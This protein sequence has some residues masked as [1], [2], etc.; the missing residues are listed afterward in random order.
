MFKFVFLSKA[1]AFVILNASLAFSPCMKMPFRFPAKPP[2]K[3]AAV[4]E[5]VVQ[6]P[7]A[8]KD[9][10]DVEEDLCSSEGINY[11]ENDAVNAAE[12]PDGMD[13]PTEDTESESDTV[14]VKIVDGKIIE[15]GSEEDLCSSEGINYPE[16]DA[17]IPDGMDDPTEDTESESDT[18]EVKIVDGKI[19]E[20]GSEDDLVAV[21]DVDDEEEKLH[22][23]GSPVV[24]DQDGNMIV[25][26]EMS[27]L[28]S[29]VAFDQDGNVIVEE[30][31]SAVGTP[32]VAALG[33]PTVAAV[34]TPT[35]A[36][37]DAIVEDDEEDLC[38]SEGI[39]YPEND[40]D[41]EATDSAEIDDTNE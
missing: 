11:P 27:M 21:P 29:P 8:E 10:K 33:T 20:V 23:L 16:N 34:G 31:M 35:I 18:V 14:E 22:M 5:P 12:I 36:A 19:I 30:E 40:Q 26:E 9:D 25:E 1:V 17:E 13:D 15:V 38:S 4:A 7:D 6:T 24:F 32:T 37:K 3:V 41:A 2:V 39:N 28:G